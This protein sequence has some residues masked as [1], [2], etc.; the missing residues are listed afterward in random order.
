MGANWLRTQFGE[1]ELAR[2]AAAAAL[3]DPMAATELSS[4]RVRARS[5]AVR[6]AHHL[7]GLPPARRRRP[8]ARTPVAGLSC[9]RRGPCAGTWARRCSTGDPGHHGRGRQ[10]RPVA[11]YTLAAI[12]VGREKRRRS[13]AAD[14]RRTGTTGA[15][16]AARELR[17]TSL[18]VVI[19]GFSGSGAA[20]R[21]ARTGRCHRGAV[22]DPYADPAAVAAAGAELITLEQALPRADVLSLHAPTAGDKAHDRRRRAGPRCRPAPR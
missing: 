9:T 18:T 2:L 13:S 6:G 4:P 16:A 20:S 22:V 21:A 15:T 19:V 7:V 1:T 17:R 14:A 5:P 10:R 8:A 12:F 3:G 11:R